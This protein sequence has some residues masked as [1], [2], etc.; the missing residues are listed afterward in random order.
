MNTR[1]WEILTGQ[2]FTHQYSPPVSP[3]SW[4]SHRRDSTTKLG[5][6]ATLGKY[7]H[8]NSAGSKS[9]IKVLA[10]TMLFCHQL[11][12]WPVNSSIIHLVRNYIQFSCMSESQ[13]VLCFFHVEA[14]GKK[15]SGLQS[16]LKPN[17]NNCWMRKQTKGYQQLLPSFRREAVKRHQQK[18]PIPWKKS[19]IFFLPVNISCNNSSDLS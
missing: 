18:E 6:T 16:S 12:F 1:H 10:Q 15:G 11:V 7:S 4:S 8:V 17:A 3:L 2:S 5:I 13:N 19:N 9:V 14:K